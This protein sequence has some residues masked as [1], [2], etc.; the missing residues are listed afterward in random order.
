MKQIVG[1]VQ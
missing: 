1:T